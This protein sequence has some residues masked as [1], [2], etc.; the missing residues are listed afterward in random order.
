[1]TEEFKYMLGEPAAPPTP[2]HTTKYSLGQVAEEPIESPRDD[3]ASDYS[4]LTTDEYTGDFKLDIESLPTSREERVEYF[5][6]IP[7]RVFNR[8]D[9][10]GF[11]LAMHKLKDDKA[12]KAEIKKLQ[13]TS[14]A[15]DNA[16]SVQ[17]QAIMNLAEKDGYYAAVLEQS[18]QR[19]LLEWVHDSGVDL[20]RRGDQW[21]VDY[22][23]SDLGFKDRVI[24]AAGDTTEEKK[25]S[26]KLVTGK[27]PRVDFKGRLLYEDVETGL[28]HSVDP[29]GL[30]KNDIADLVPGTPAFTAAMALALFSP[31]KQQAGLTFGRILGMSALES[32]GYT[33]GQIISDYLEQQQGYNLE[34]LDDLASRYASDWGYNFA[35]TTAFSQGA[36]GV[37][38]FLNN[39]LGGGVKP[40]HRSLADSVREILAERASRNREEF[41]EVIQGMDRFQKLTPDE[42]AKYLEDPDLLMREYK[43]TP[44]LVND[45][46]IAGRVSGFLSNIPGSAGIYDSIQNA[47]LRLLEEEIQWLLKD[48]HNRHT[49][50]PLIQ[51]KLWQAIQANYQ[52]RL[53]LLEL[54]RNGESV[55]KAGEII[56]DT[57]TLGYNN[58][59]RRADELAVS[60]DTILNPT[61]QLI[62]QSRV[63]P[64]KGIVA[65]YDN[66][67]KDPQVRKE[68]ANAATSNKEIDKRLG[69]MIKR[70]KG[71]ST[72]E[73]LEITEEGLLEFVE[74]EVTED[75]YLTTR[76]YRLIQRD[77]GYIINKEPTL[78]MTIG[79]LADSLHPTQGKDIPGNKAMANRFSALGHDAATYEKWVKDFNRYNKWYKENSMLWDASETGD[80]RSVFGKILKQYTKKGDNYGG[81]MEQILNMLV[82]LS[83]DA[84]KGA[85]YSRKYADLFMEMAEPEDVKYLQ[86]ALVNRIIGDGTLMDRTPDNIIGLLNMSK[87][88][89]QIYRTILGDDTLASLDVMA[90]YMRDMK[91]NPAF[92]IGIDP[93]KSS[94][95]ASGL[96]K[97]GGSG[98]VGSDLGVYEATIKQFM[99]S[100]DMQG[101]QAVEGLLLEEII[102]PALKHV[103]GNPFR[104][105]SGE[106][107]LD[108]IDH[109][110][111]DALIRAFGSTEEAVKR[112][113]VIE[114][115]AQM[116]K[117]RQKGDKAG[118]LAAGMFLANTFLRGDMMGGLVTMAKMNITARVFFSSP[119]TKWLARDPI[120]NSAKQQIRDSAKVMF[121]TTKLL[122]GL[123]Q[124]I[125]PQ[126]A[127]ELEAYHEELWRKAEAHVDKQLRLSN[128]QLRREFGEE[129]KR[130]PSYRTKAS[131]NAWLEGLK[132]K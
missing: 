18:H 128:I 99:D 70:L 8:L 102:K 117:A 60:V 64:T 27:T 1:M 35:M 127:K 73:A 17:K 119:M 90:Q 56:Y 116:T 13:R 67:F 51:E 85:K 121:Y 87:E 84:A 118:G 71:V 59:K 62:E 72:E 66:I 48:V 110:G 114:D 107:L 26:V 103:P 125:E 93:N 16:F 126:D 29:L 22:T 108:Q 130:Q 43:L 88:S 78:R 7:P 109:Y 100:G 77:L 112:V 38:S 74:R 44:V 2:Q 89:R 45:S 63:I 52:K 53:S 32:S 14:K 129:V 41:N 83:G 96:I 86:D 19:K 39:P 94:V 91:N 69:D 115:L 101:V 50:A 46:A 95:I 92:Q 42:Q 113:N 40:E 55:E 104:V 34:S 54:T 5:S 122:E 75:V 12:F 124:G 57:L 82:P 79:K 6:N 11:G 30:D 49:Y 15:G 65:E 98:G 120:Q 123:E 58:F 33:G 4:L 111:K 28:F 76:E 80:P 25:R 3:L 21:L 31:F 105:L 37:S 68:I 97:K 81:G 47:N 23:Q 131:H 10:Q 36:V 9:L 132:N 20:S 61:G 24:V 106:A